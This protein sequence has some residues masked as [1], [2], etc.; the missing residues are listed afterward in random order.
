[1]R[2]LCWILV[3]RNGSAYVASPIAHPPKKSSILIAASA[4]AVIELAGNAI[5]LCVQYGKDVSNA[6]D[7][8]GRIKTEVTNLKTVT[9]GVR[10]LL[11]G[12]QGAKL[13]ASQNLNTTLQ[14]GQ[15]ELQNLEEDL[16][17]G[18]GR[19]A[20]RQSAFAL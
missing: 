13:H 10:Q 4:L 20:M 5:K 19:K 15:G 8:I 1:M 17:P 6:K 7:D 3:Q 14:D 16:T 9:D 18:K 11:G 2:A 12:P